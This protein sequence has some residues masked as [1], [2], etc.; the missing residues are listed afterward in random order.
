MTRNRHAM[1][2]V[3]DPAAD[4]HNPFV[5]PISFSTR[6]PASSNITAVLEAANL[7]E[8]SPAFKAEDLCTLEDT[9]GMTLDE[10]R[11]VFENQG[12][13]PTVG[14]IRRC[15]A[16][17]QSAEQGMAQ[18]S[19]SRAVRVPGRALSRV[20]ANRYFQ[21]LQP[22]RP[23]GTSTSNTA[24]SRLRAFDR[25]FFLCGAVLLAAGLPGGIRRLRTRLHAPAM[26]PMHIALILVG[27]ACC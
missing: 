16:V 7:G 6:S 5:T 4:P 24:V 13:P 23:T 1:S 21:P 3:S 2:A 11:R 14:R 20:P 10:I 26:L 27:A 22:T 17:L 8:L 12:Q 19:A 25:S 9:S 15:Y 18:L